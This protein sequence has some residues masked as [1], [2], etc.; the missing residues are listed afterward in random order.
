MGDQPTQ[1]EL[2]A[3]RAYLERGSARLAAAEIGCREQTVKNH[4][5]ALRQKYG[6][7]RTF[8]VAH[9]LRDKLVA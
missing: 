9:L 5:H 4:L 1:A 8:Q 2:R 6:V 3:L 7:K